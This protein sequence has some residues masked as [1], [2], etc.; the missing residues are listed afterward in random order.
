MADRINI[1]CTWKH[2]PDE[3]LI[4]LFI[5]GKQFT[6]WAYEDD[7]KD[8]FEEFERIYQAGFNKALNPSIQDRLKLE[9][10]LHAQEARTQRCTVHEIYQL[11]GSQ[12]GD[13]NGAVPVKEFIQ[14]IEGALCEYHQALSDRKHGGVA[15]GELVTKL[16]GILG[17][18]WEN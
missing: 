5:D 4:D 3:G 16:E 12:K 9:A 11:I 1:D 8:C 18:H 2:D 7:P 15:A 10:Q 14:S 6:T 17:I 13:W